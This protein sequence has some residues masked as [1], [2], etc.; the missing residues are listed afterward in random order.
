MPDYVKLRNE[1]I[2]PVAGGGKSYAGQ[3]DDPFFLDLRIFDLLY[4]GDFSEVGF[5]TLAEYNVNTVALQLPKSAFAANGDAGRNPVIGVWSTTSRAQ[6]RVLANNNATPTAGLNEDSDEAR[7]S[8]NFVQVSRL[9][10]P[11]VNEAVVPANLK[12]F[13]NRSTPDTDGKFIKKVQDPEVPILVEQVYKVPNPNKLDNE[14][15]KNRNDVVAAFLT[16]FSRDVFAGRTFGGAGKGV[17]DA[18]LN[19]LDLNE[20]SPNP[21][22]AE[23][24]RLNMSVAPKGPASP[25][26]SRL[27]ALGGD[28]SGFPNG[29]RLTDDVVDI[30]L[31]L[32]EGKLLRPA[33]DPNKATVDGLGDAVNS[34]ERFRPLLPSFP[35][36]ADPH[37][38]S[39]P[40]KGQTPVM[41]QQNFTS[42]R[43]MV[44]ANATRI[45]PAARGGFAQLYRINADGST[46]G[47][48]SS[49]ISANGQAT[50]T[51]RFPVRPGTRITLNWRVFP[52]RGSAAQENRGVPTTITVR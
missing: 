52:K 31:Q 2:T 13:F 7:D 36:V 22:A 32:L 40:R 33:G 11:L 4:G 39:D 46:T 24:L 6:N 34:N 16:G 48:G 14:A 38:G 35:F 47:L 17:L 10:N 15:A 27:G 23:Y 49:P 12:D 43:G 20:V 9:G 21:V 25:G 50:V 29:R 5:D 28:L 42:E 19:S 41:F 18:D 3:A 45:T 1:A 51:K 44:T 8:G 30:A 37:A 26:F